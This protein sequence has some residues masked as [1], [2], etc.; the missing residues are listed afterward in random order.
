MIFK[1]FICKDNYTTAKAPSNIELKN[2]NEKDPNEVLL[3]PFF[4]FR[5]AHIEETRNKITVSLRDHN[6]K[7]A[8][9]EGKITIVTLMEVP[10]QKTVME[11]PLGSLI[12]HD[13]LI[14]SE[15]KYYAETLS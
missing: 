7:E 8:K 9:N 3:L 6:D 12:T 10:F 2:E 14:L 1:I 4:T 11:K 5:V 13:S 15:S